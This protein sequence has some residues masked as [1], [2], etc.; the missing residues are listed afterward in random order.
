MEEIEEIDGVKGR[1]RIL[2][3]KDHKFKKY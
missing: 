3:G 2:V 1:K